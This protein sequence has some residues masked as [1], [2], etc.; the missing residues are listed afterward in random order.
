MLE[1]LS[2]RFSDAFK[3]IQGKH[4][5]SSENIE[6]VLTDIRTALLEADVNFKVVKDFI[7]SVKEKSLGEKVLR[8]VNPDQQFVKIIHDELKRIMGG[9]DA[10]ISLKKS[11]TVFLIVGLN[12]AGKTTFS[13]KLALHLKSKHQKKVLLIPADTF[14]P[15]AKAQLQTLAKT[16]AVDCYDSDLSLTPAELVRQAMKKA[17]EENYQVVIV[18]SAGRLHVDEALMNELHLLR[19][20]LDHW[21][22]ETLFVAD[23]MTGQEAVEVANHFHQK[24]QLTGL[25]LSKMDSDAR[26]GSALSIRYHTGIPIR[27]LSV[28]EKLK[29][30]EAFDPDRMAKRILDMGDVVGLVEKAQESIDE[31]D[32]AQMMEKLSKKQLTLDDFI[33][34]MDVINKMGPLSS[35]LKMIPGMGGML[36]SVGDLSPAQDEM[37]RMKVMASSMTK[38][39]KNNH[40]LFKETGRIHRVAKGS[41]RSE[42]EVREFLKKFEQMRTMMLSMMDM[43]NG[44]NL[45]ALGSM[46]G[47]GGD[48]RQ[49]MPG[50]PPA[51]G[52]RQA[53]QQS[54]KNRSGDGKQKKRG[55]FGK[56][57]FS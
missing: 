9:D 56:N 42:Q 39:E 31:A 4:K 11:P 5:I 1:T 50:M 27:F 53:P 26:G 57:F 52:F 10:E 23:A 7:Q 17:E 51:K 6:Q 46:M 18:D 40:K 13:A 37:K 14:R 8:G 38:A 35:L 43:M 36:R 16:A 33:K 15:A 20:S 41:G 3:K 12:G 54:L 29:D 25:I 45:G 44:G 19:K 30:L 34:Q 2:E 55:P 22:P 28:G 48:P 49:G 47:M 32:A 21:N 24:I